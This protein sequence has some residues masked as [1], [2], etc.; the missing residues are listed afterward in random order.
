MA[1][2]LAPLRV[3]C[4]KRVAIA[5]RRASSSRRRP[6][7][8]DSSAGAPVLHFYTLNR[9]KATREIF[10]NLRITV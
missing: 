10:A 9:S 2:A 3:K 4:R 8:L 1:H 7:K 5:F 6:T